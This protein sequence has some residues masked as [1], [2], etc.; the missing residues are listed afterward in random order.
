MSGPTPTAGDD[1]RTRQA[2]DEASVKAADTNP[3][4]HIKP[5]DGQRPFQARIIQTM[6][7]RHGAWLAL[8]LLVGQDWRQFRGPS[9]QGIAESSGAPT[10][11]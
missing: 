4:R 10:E 9:G 8:A 5:L 1:D 11:P 3:I 7:K 6:Q 2:V